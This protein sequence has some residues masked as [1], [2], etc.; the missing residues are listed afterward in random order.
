M[1]RGPKV[2]EAE[3]SQVL[4]MKQ[5]GMSVPTIASKLK[6][7][8]GLVYQILE[9][10]EAT[11]VPTPV[12]A[13]TTHHHQHEQAHAV[14]AR[15]EPAIGV[16]SAPAPT[17]ASGVSGIGSGAAITKATITRPP[18]VIPISRVPLAQKGGNDAVSSSMVCE[19]DIRKPNYRPSARKETIVSP[20]AELMQLI[21]GMAPEDDVED[22][23]S[24]Q[25]S[26]PEA[27]ES[28]SKR[29]HGSPPTP[30]TNANAPPV[31]K[32]TV[33]LP[34]SVS[35]H[36]SD[37]TSTSKTTHTSFLSAASPSHQPTCCGRVLFE[38]PEIGI[39]CHPLAK[40][41][42]TDSTKAAPNIIQPDEDPFT[43]SK[44]ITAKKNSVDS[45][46]R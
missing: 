8:T 9:A 20:D 29:Q 24:T 4:M 25:P 28:S 21:M 7:S 15:D 2:S 14:A 18:K 31:T 43:A 32:S 34:T 38:S 45:F 39:C 13:V 44:D 26:Q 19:N 30:M 6:R 23:E 5:S 42:K 37:A 12:A 10:F 36:S 41:N 46:F 3:K 27:E 33:V 16:V 1:G 22:G 11:A 40:K 35:Q 17:V